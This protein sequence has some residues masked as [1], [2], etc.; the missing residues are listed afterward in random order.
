MLGKRGVER[1]PMPVVAPTPSN[2]VGNGASCEE[3][4]IWGVRRRERGWRFGLVSLVSALAIVGTAGSGQAR[5]GHLS[6]HL[7][8]PDASGVLETLST[9]PVMDTSNPF[10]QVLGTN[11]RTCASCHVPAA[12]WSV[13]PAEAQ[14]RVMEVN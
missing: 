8:F 4:A 6:R 9:I 11:G 3:G 13:T 1:G 10:F 14:A 7:T 2:D 5:T 12:D